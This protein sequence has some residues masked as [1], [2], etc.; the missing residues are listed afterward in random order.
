MGAKVN[1]G[2]PAAAVTGFGSVKPGPRLPA[3]G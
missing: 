3:K 2:A 1:I